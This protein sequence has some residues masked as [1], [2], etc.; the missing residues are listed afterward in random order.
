MKRQAFLFVDG[1]NMIG[2]WPN[3]RSLQA[4]D[5]QGARDLLLEELAN[6]AKVRQLQIIVVFDAQ[7]VPGA[8]TVFEQDPLQV[9]FTEEEET[10]DSYIER[11]VRDYIHPLHSVSVATSDRAEQWTIFQQGALRMSAQELWLDIKR[12]KE[13]VATEVR[14][15]YNRHLR[16][17]S[18]WSE[19]QWARLDHLRKTL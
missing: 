2:A 7:F 1:Y 15:Y 4:S 13:E 6:Y 16:R 11:G 5:I 8:R 18:P 19:D 3:L 17:H 14:R 12:A 9:V 10:A